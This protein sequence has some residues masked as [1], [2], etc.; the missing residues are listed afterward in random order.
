MKTYKHMKNI[1]FCR[2]LTRTVF[3][4]LFAAGCLLTT[5]AEVSQSN[6]NIDAIITN[7]AFPFYDYVAHNKVFAGIVKK[8][9]T[10]QNQSLRQIKRMKM[11]L[12]QCGDIACYATA[13][14]WSPDE[15]AAI[16]ERLMQLCHDNKKMHRL[17]EVLKAAEQYNLYDTQTDTAFIRSVWN[18]AALGVNRILDTYIKGKKP[19]YSAIDAISFPDNDAGFRERVRQELAELVKQHTRKDLFFKLPL[20]LALK[21]LAINDRDEAARY[22]PLDQGMNK[23]AV[24]SIPSIQW[25]SFPYSMILV[26]GQGLER[27]GLAI[28]PMGISR[29]RLAAER[30]QKGLAPF[31]VVSGGHVHP[32]KTSYS[33]AVEMKKYMVQELRIPEKAILIEPHARHTTT[34]LR[35]TVRLVYRYKIPDNMKILTVTDSIQNAYIPKMEKRFIEELGYIP[36]RD[37]KILST[38]ENEFYPVKNALQVN[39]FDPLDP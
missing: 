4:F 3:V 25:A 14:Q 38:E 7:K 22:E 11:A 37:L 5:Y 31:I 1:M 35:N 36:Y 8:D 17:L 23:S 32:N 18:D 29:C 10:F 27:E 33:E 24:E 28:D 34:N 20:K 30:Y 39:P 2:F 6:E 15:I 13:A 9:A 19:R 16:G 21:A 26:P 12:E